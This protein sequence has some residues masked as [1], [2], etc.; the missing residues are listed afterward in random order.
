MSIS[1]V[2]ERSIYQ[3]L[4]VC[5]PDG[6]KSMKITL[7]FQKDCPEQPEIIMVGG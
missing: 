7:I 4:N 6:I 3:S 5:R 1:K 2:K